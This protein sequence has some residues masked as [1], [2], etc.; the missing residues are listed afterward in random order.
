MRYRI[1]ILFVM[2]ATPALAKSHPPPPPVDV[3]LH[4]QSG[5]VLYQTSP[6]A[7]LEHVTTSRIIS[8]DS[9]VSTG[10]SS[11]GILEYPEKSHVVLGQNTTVQVG[12]FTRKGHLTS[13]WVRIPPTGGALRFDV[14]HEE[15]GESSFMFAT[16]LAEVTVRG[17]TALLS[18]GI[19]GVT[20]A[21][22]V[23]QAGDV[24]AHL[25]GRDYAVLTGE[26]MRITPAGRVTIDKTSDEV[27]ETFADTGLSTMLPPPEPKPT[28]RRFRFPKIRL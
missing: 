23:C 9:L 15:N 14:R 27:L 24:V 11:T 12:A 17:T 3:A 7:R 5:T 18:D 8:H 6:T 26:T 10:P 22:L 1:A 16:S 2:L 13:T 4:W 21:C 25:R 20:I 19:T 28:P